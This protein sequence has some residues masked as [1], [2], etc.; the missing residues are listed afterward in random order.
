MKK[1]FSFLIT[2]FF[3][4]Q[5]YASN[6]NLQSI[7]KIEMVLTV[8][9]EDLIITHEGINVIFNNALLEVSSLERSED[10]WLV[11]AALKCPKGHP[12]VC[13]YCRGCA[14]SGC[15][16]RCMGGCSDTKKN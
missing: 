6:T 11:K 15:P 2:F 10:Y 13:W 3:F 16:Y 7:Q 9:A 14:V 8:C 4:G 1:F 5:I 12:T